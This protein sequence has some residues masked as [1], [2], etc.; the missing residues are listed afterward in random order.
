MKPLEKRIESN[1]YKNHIKKLLLMLTL[2]SLSILLFSCQGEQSIRPTHQYYINDFAGVLTDATVINI[3]AEGTRLFNDTDTF[4]NSGTQLV[5]STFL[6]DNQEQVDAYDVTQLFNR[7]S[8]GEK[9]MG[10]LVLIFFQKTNNTIELIDTKIELGTQL[11]K[12][13][14]KAQLELIIDQSLYHATWDDD[15]FIDLPIMLMYYEILESIYMNA[16]D[17]VSFTYNMEVYEQ[18]IQTYRSDIKPSRTS[19]SYIEYALFQIGIDNEFFL[20]SLSM[21]AVLL[22]SISY[23]VIRKDRNLTILKRKR[24]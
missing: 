6:V 3:T 2:L 10:L 8:V 15:D 4:I 16:Y 21:F 5:V 22:I 20:I 19:M 17:Y 23:Y 18:Y 9:E 11:V 14:T 1:S 24:S 12:Y 7:W 13:V